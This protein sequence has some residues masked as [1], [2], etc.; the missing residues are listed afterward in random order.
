M[1]AKQAFLIVDVQN[2]FC[3]GGALAV[4]H[5]ETIV[6]FLNRYIQDFQNKNIPILASRDWH[7]RKTTHFKE[8]GGLWPVH[9]VENTVGAQ[10]H[11]QLKLPPETI[12]ISKGMEP[13]QDGYSAFE[14]VDHRGQFL[15]EILTESGIEELYVGG[16][17]TDYCVKSSCLDA[18][19]FG[20]RVNLLM[21]AIKAVNLKPQDA[22]TALQEMVQNGVRCVT[23]PELANAKSR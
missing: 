12:I 14:G 7:P 21:D 9:C 6:P 16:L 15:L 3:P 18:R 17:A 8:F 11:P 19:K 13:D 5:G 20:F 23:F 4:P 22:Q 10:F 2:D 1:E